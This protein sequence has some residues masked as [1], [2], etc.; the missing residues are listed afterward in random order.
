MP[1]D[2]HAGYFAR[3]ASM[4][5]LPKRQGNVILQGAV[6]YV[7]LWIGLNE[8]PSEKEGKYI[9]Q[10]MVYFISGASMKALPKRKGNST[11]EHSQPPPNPPQ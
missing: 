4:K 11:P 10:K 9:G 1:H 5:A 6:A 8:S 3:P 2:F 7:L